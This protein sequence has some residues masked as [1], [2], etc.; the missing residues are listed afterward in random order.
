MVFIIGYVFG[1]FAKNA[2]LRTITKIA[3]ILAIVLFV[4]TNIL[5]FRFGG[6]HHRGYYHGKA[7]CGYYQD[8]TGRK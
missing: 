2:T 4:S 3:A 8:S 5:L 7:D 1:G 6:W